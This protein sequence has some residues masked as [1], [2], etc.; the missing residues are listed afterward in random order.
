MYRSLITFCVKKGDEERF[1]QAFLAAGMLERPKLV[2]GFISVELSKSCI[3]P[4]QFIV[5]GRWQSE[6]SYASWQKVAQTDAP[7]DA[8]K[9]LGQCLHETPTGELHEVIAAS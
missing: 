3:T 2:E 1:E 9:A 6:E 8:L 7:R 4:G 5:V